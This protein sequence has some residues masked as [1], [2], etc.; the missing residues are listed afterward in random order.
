ME[1]KTPKYE[2][3]NKLSNDDRHRVVIHYLEGYG[4]YHIAMTYGV[5][6]STIEYH[7]KK[8]NVFVPHKK[9]TLFGDTNPIV[10]REINLKRYLS[11]KV[12]EDDKKFWYDEF[13]EK[14]HWPKSYKQ[15][16]RTYK[17]YQRNHPTIKREEPQ[18]NGFLI[19]V[20]FKTNTVITRDSKG[21]YHIEQREQRPQAFC[22]SDSS[23]S[24]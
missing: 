10:K 14:Y 21:A 1:M 22:I 3:Y 24:W 16:V 19:K 15:L 11:V 13:G 5:T 2:W 6:T 20:S 8:A 23:L 4:L 12:P 18:S 9:P 17:N 7:L